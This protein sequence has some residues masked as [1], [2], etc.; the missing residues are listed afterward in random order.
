MAGIVFGVSAQEVPL[1]ETPQGKVFGGERFS[2]RLDAQTGWPGE[3]FC[4][5]QRVVKAAG[6]RQAFDLKQGE[7][8]ITG[9]GSKI[10]G[11]GIE[12]LA[13]DT[14]KSRMRIGDW[15]I[16]ACL[17]LF[18]EARMLRRW[19]E[20]TWQG[21]AETKVKGFWLQGGVLPLGEGGGFFYPAQYPPRRTA[22]KAL[23][24]GRR[25]SSGRSPYP[26][27]G[28]TGS[29]W[30]AV[31]MADELPDYSDRGSVSVTEE[32][33]QIRVTQSFNMQGRLRKGVTQKVG[34]AWLWLQPND[35]ETALRRMGEW[36][37]LVKQVPPADRPEWLKR[38]VLYSF[39]PGGTI[40]S[41][42]QDLGGFAA[43]TGFL[44][45]IRELGCNAIWLMPL[46]DKSIYW[47]RDY[48]KFQEGLGTPEDYKALTAKAHALGLRVWQDCVPHG[49]CNEFPR[50]KEH[51]EWLAQNEDGSTL[52]YWCFDF[53]WPTWIDYMSGVVS[54]YT[55][56]YGLDGFRIDAVG[57]SYIPNWNPAIPYARA[58]H[59]Q[60]QGGLDMQRALRAS[61][62]AVRP[63]GANLAEVGQSIHG[64][65]SDSTYDF[66]LCYNVLHDFRRVPADE[67]APRLRRWLHEQQCAEIPDLV[68][69]RHVESHD[70]LRSG[71]WY[72]ADAQRALVALLS[73]IHGIP[74]VYHEMEDGS[75]DVYRR[76]FHVRNCVAELNSGA[77]DYLSVTAPEGVFACLRTGA[78]PQKGAA[79][80][81]ADYA[82]DTSPK[83]SDRASVTLVNLSGKPVSGAV[84]V[85]LDALP[86]SLRDARMARDLLSGATVKVRQGVAEVSLPPLG[87]TVLRFESKPLPELAPMGQTERPETPVA[88]GVTLR[89]KA[90]SGTLLVDA[91]TGWATGWKTGWT[92]VPLTLD[93]ALPKPLADAGSAVPARIQSHDGTLEVTY[94][95]GGRSLALTYTARGEGVEVRATWQGGVPPE[96]ALMVGLPAAERWFAS[97]AEGVFDSPFRVR[98]PG[99]DGAVGSIYRLPQGTATLW[100]SRLHPFG[101]G[102][103][104]A[105]VGATADG[106]RVSLGF[107]PARLPAA[108]QLLDRVGDTHG[109][110]VLAGWQSEANGAPAGGDELVFTVRTE[111]G[112]G[113]LPSAGTGDARLTAVGG[114]WV[115]ENAF[116]RARVG[117]SG[118]LAGLWRKEGTAWQPVLRQAKL[119][120]DKGFGG[121]KP[122]SQE[123]DVEA[124]ARIERRDGAVTLRFCGELRGFY[125][126]DKMAHPIRFYSAYT[127]GDGP[128]FRQVHAYNAEAL[129]SPDF[130]FLSLLSKVEGAERVAFADAAGEFLAGERGDGKARYAQTAK[131]ADARRLPGDIRIRTAGG[132]ALRLC[133]VAWIGVKPANVFM[134]GSDLHVAWMDGPPDNRGVGQ[135]N[136][137]SMS[138]ACGDNA[139]AAKDEA[140]LAQGGRSG[141]VQ[142]GGFE[143]TDRAGA[144]LLS[145]RLA[146][147]RAEKASVAWQLPKGAGVVSEGSGRCVTV[148]GDGVEYRMLRQA[149]QVQAFPA[150]SAWRLT[151]RLKGLGVEKAD[152]GWKTACLRWGVTAGGRTEYRAV[153]LPFGDSDWREV[154][155]EMTVPAGVS[156]IT[157]EAGLNGNKGRVWIDDVS[158]AKIR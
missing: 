42:C 33:G 11:L 83:G 152:A 148:E 10:Q 106:R 77:A 132:G 158:V 145:A 67:F 103:A 69:M 121:D 101:L 14:I 150:G 38:V 59:A 75:F 18:P 29:G 84:S 20:I 34:D 76:I 8:W 153:S 124:T 24:P 136:G 19:F 4:D 41:Q 39:H 78:L 47:P 123:D 138:V 154:S 97:A 155:V 44:T 128:A 113:A 65:V 64:A 30:S 86:A 12:R 71:L 89:V 141:V 72:G 45:H 140:P 116:Y 21:E 96:A 40:G 108:V 2:V 56:E 130:A 15:S 16:V 62:K 53:N 137:V 13:P 100:D 115:F 131:S 139:V 81:H 25:S 98:H 60:A 147:P 55:R 134:H 57:G 157:V 125:R 127:F 23:E 48:Y 126:F 133:D 110:K 95:F 61:V 144:V 74:M 120:T 7:G 49:G 107:D 46:E 80:W 73:W 43:A 129:A 26:V 79:A 111:P 17:Q 91:K 1:R 93:L 35:A 6:T 90:K 32:A 114:G 102:A 122:Y 105:R 68:R 54:F 28:E 51:P 27:I 85:P 3:V 156:A 92:T 58:S 5:G 146:L 66:D 37:R 104:G 142:D 50:A 119:Y 63:D 112:D 87:Y 143:Q 52:H 151:A 149:L 22:A 82:W 117:R 9:D 109:L 88:S 118:A 70:S 99:F 31:W 94:A 36:F 135:W